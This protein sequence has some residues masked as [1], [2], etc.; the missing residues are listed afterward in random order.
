MNFLELLSLNY[1]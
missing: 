1:F